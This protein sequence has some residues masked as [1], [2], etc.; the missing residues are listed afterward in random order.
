MPSIRRVWMSHRNVP[1]KD[2]WNLLTYPELKAETV[3]GAETVETAKASS[4]ELSL[5]LRC[6]TGV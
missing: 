5:A 2:V 6:G 4:V 3:K 1:S